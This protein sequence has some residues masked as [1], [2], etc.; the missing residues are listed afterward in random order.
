V[1]LEQLATDDAGVA[2]CRRRVAEQRAQ[3]GDR[4][5]VRAQVG[6]HL[7]QARQLGLGAL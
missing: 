6:E 4:L 3:L 2:H 1:S 5:R 7:V